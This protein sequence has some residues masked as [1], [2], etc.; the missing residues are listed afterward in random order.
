[1]LANR[2]ATVTTCHVH[3]RDLAEHTRRA[4]ILCVAV[5]KP[6]LV[7]ADMV[8]D[9]V[10]VVDV[11]VNRTEGGKLVGDVDFDAISKKASYITPVPGGVGPMTVACLMENIVKAAK[12]LHNLTS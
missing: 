5:G 9:G 11:G 6:G 8:K 2:D 10:V 1:M 4:D 12:R 7:K 3:T